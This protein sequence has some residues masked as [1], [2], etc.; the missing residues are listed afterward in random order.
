M[1]Y[2]AMPV[3][4]V[5]TETD[6][7]DYEHFRQFLFEQAN[8]LLDDPLRSVRPRSFRIL[9]FRNSEQQHRWDPSFKS[10]SG[11]PKHFVGRKLKNAWHRLDGSP[12]LAAT[13][14]K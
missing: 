9:A 3:I 7:R 1:N 14:N 8:C 5:L 4:H 11:L 2:S 12:H 13:S 10:S 6:V